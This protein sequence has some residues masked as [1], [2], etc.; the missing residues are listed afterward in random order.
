MYNYFKNNN[1]NIF[2][3]GK[4]SYVDKIIPRITL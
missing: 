1:M 3:V 4:K 2:I